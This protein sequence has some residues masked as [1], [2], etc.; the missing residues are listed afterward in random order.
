MGHFGHIKV[1]QIKAF[2]KFQQFLLKTSS[3]M[4]LDGSGKKRPAFIF[5][6]W[7]TFGLWSRGHQTGKIVVNVAFVQYSCNIVL[8]IFLSMNHHDTTCHPL[9]ILYKEFYNKLRRFNNRI[10]SF[11]YYL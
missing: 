1:R 10:Y 3:P 9:L 8:I 4:Y 5:I 6:F 7:P 11:L 2:Q